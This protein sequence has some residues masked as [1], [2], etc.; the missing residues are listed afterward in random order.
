MHKFYFTD[1]ATAFGLAT[2]LPLKVPANKPLMYCGNT[3][4]IQAEIRIENGLVYRCRN[5]TFEA[6]CPKIVENATV[7]DNSKSDEISTVTFFDNYKENV[8]DQN[9]KLNIEEEYFDDTTVENIEES[10]LNSTESNS[11]NCEK[12][13]IICD[14]EEIQ[15]GIYCKNGTLFSAKEIFCNSTTILKA[16]KSNKTIE[17]LNCYKGKL[18]ENQASFIPT[19]TDQAPTTTT[20][21]EKSYSIGAQM[22][23]FML[24]LLGKHQI[25]EKKKNEIKEE[26]KWT[27][28]ALE[29]LPKSTT[30]RTT[31]TTT[32][33]PPFKW[34]MKIPSWMRGG[35]NL[36][37]FDYEEPGPGVVSLH[38]TILGMQRQFGLTTTTSSW[39][40]VKVY[41]TT[42]TE[43]SL[44]TTT[45][46]PITTTTD[47][48]S[49]EIYD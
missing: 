22:H 45:E 41:L 2:L 32:P 8:E 26:P 29:I 14:E 9:I 33:E 38:H 20:T 40:L 43:E 21:T 30:Q 35:D 5:G 17:I 27:P 1:A 6:R 3:A 13:K 4:L 23:I 16:T 48:Y 46:L 19:T 39:G 10:E 12:R 28:E 24:K 18:S 37:S 36:Y 44:T 34:M 47:E 15:K 42:T 31:T 7:V 49:Y 25:L 11:T